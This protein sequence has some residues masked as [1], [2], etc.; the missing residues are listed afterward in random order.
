[1]DNLDLELI[2]RDPVSRRAFLTRM[3]AAGLGVAA[4]GLLNGSF[5]GLAETTGTAP[6]AGGMGTGG[7]GTG[8]G[9]DGTFELGT[10]V[11]DATNFP[12]IPGRSINET[13]LNFA[14]TLERLEADLYRQALNHASGKSLAA[15]LTTASDYTLAVPAGRLDQSGLGLNT[16]KQTGDAFDYLRDFTFVE[17]AHRDFI[18]MAMHK[19]HMT[20]VAAYPGGY[21]FPGGP[22]EDLRTILA[23]ILPLEETGVRAY[24]GAAPFLTSLALV[25]VATTIYSTEARHSAVV[26]DTIG[27]DPGP[28]T[29][30]GDKFVVANQPSFNTFEHYLEPA[31]VVTRASRYFGK[32]TRPTGGNGTPTP[33]PTNG[34]GSPTPS[35][36]HGGGS[37]TP[38]PTQNGGSPTPGPTNSGGSPT[39]TPT[40]GGGVPTPAPTQGG[41]SPTPAPTQGGGAPGP[42][43]TPSP[44][45]PRK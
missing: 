10:H 20:P 13:V 15:P 29:Y 28:R 42:I 36:T 40:N 41:G 30:P 18:I 43:G 39:P 34:G 17:A 12:L 5:P 37:P 7:T 24:L 23:N 26:S 38:A 8:M 16:D 31:T 44:V 22:G 11:F 9:A 6:G 25:Q 19:M 1:M 35:P 27:I 33:G 4:L 3:G 2:Q 14:L 32:I 21:R 45:V